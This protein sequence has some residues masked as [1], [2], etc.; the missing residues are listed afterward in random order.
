MSST[1]H[2]DRSHP[3]S[4]IVI[5]EKP[6]DDELK[7]WMRE[8]FRRYAIAQ[9]GYDED[10]DPVA[11]VAYVGDSLAGMIVVTL[12]WGILYINK[13]FVDETYRGQGLASGLM[14]RALS[15]G[16]ENKCPI[17][18]VNTLSFQALDFYQKHGF[19]CEFTRTGFSHDIKVHHLRKDL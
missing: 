16:R 12:F 18:Y 8:G 11:F 2:P 3:P 10:C 5:R 1:H 9:I 17:A 4:P 14:E 19:R 15:F 13:L 6:F 7:K